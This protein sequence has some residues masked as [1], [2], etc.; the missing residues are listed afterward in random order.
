MNRG[1]LVNEEI[2]VVSTK[3]ESRIT[4]DGKGVGAGNFIPI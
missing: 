4:V 1:Y 2:R 3:K